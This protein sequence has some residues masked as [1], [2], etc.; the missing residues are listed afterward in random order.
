MIDLRS[1]HW[2]PVGTSSRDVE[3]RAQEATRYVWLRVCEHCLSRSVLWR[4]GVAHCLG[5]DRVALF[6]A[7]ERVQPGEHA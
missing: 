4:A 5:C 6:G 7:G 1:T 2:P 3:T